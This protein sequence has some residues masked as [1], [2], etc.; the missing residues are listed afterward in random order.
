MQYLEWRQ[1]KNLVHCKT[2]ED[3]TMQKIRTGTWNVVT[4]TGK[5]TELMNALMSWK[6]PFVLE[7]KWKEGKVCGDRREIQTISLASSSAG[8]P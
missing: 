4:L 6:Y 2:K 8:R 3:D 5:T 1:V 7:M